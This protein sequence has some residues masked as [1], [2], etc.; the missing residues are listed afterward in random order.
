MW[1]WTVVSASGFSVAAVSLG[2]LPTRAA[3]EAITGAIRNGASQCG[4]I[5]GGFHGRRQRAR[6]S[7]LSLT[8]GA[9]LMSD[10]LFPAFKLDRRSPPGTQHVHERLE[11]TYP[12]GAVP[13]WAG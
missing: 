1:P 2:S 13:L 11:P 7:E 3:T 5:A 12:E 6:A 9:V 8:P 4:W 10:R